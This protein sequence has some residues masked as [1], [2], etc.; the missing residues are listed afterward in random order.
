MNPLTRLRAAFA[1]DSFYWFLGDIPELPAPP[2]PSCWRLLSQGEAEAWVRDHRTERA[3]QRRSQDVALENKHLLFVASLEGRDVGHVWGA[4]GW[5]Y[6]ERP[7]C[8]RVHLS[9]ETTYFYDMFVDKPYRRRGVA[10]DGFR[11]RLQTVRHHGLRRD[12][13]GVISGNR[14]GRRNVQSLGL[15]SWEALRFRVGRRAFWIKGRPWERIADQVVTE[16]V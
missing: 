15:P 4:R 6:A 11:V 14:V 13:A 7:D 10:S 3:D 2:D 8:V 16:R 5:M 12:A 9:P 1:L